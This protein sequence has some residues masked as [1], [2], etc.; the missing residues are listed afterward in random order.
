M[1]ET[2]MGHVELRLAPRMQSVVLQPHYSAWSGYSM[3]F[4]SVPPLLRVRS[5][6]CHMLKVNFIFLLFSFLLPVFPVLLAVF[7]LP[8]PGALPAQGKSVMREN[9]SDIVGL[10]PWILTNSFLEFLTDG[11]MRASSLRRNV[12][13]CTSAMHEVA[14]SGSQTTSHGDGQ[15]ERTDR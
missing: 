5:N 7:F 13:N 14:P 11:V 10:C 6:A 8:L 3:L 1:W 15:W 2:W 4:E 9:E 12:S